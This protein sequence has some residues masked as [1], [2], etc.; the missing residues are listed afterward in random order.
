MAIFSLVKMNP[1]VVLYMELQLHLQ[2][3]VPG[4]IIQQRTLQSF[5]DARA[6]EIRVESTRIC[7]LVST[8]LTYISCKTSES[9]YM[10]IKT[11]I[12]KENIFQQITVS[13]AYGIA[14]TNFN[15]VIRRIVEQKNQMT[16]S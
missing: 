10:I 5:E 3:T 14:Y 7:I 9:G 1:L 15:I 13:F 12:S 6:R 11:S 8:Y 16:K 2:L 4:L